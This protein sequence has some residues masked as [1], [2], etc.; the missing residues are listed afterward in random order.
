MIIQS[1]Q[2]SVENFQFKIIFLW[3]E[4]F[5]QINSFPESPA[6]DLGP[7]YYQPLPPYLRASKEIY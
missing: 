6:D 2:Y 7:N 1:V 5:Q 3:K 4:P